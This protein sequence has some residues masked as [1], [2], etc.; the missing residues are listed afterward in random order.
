MVAD[1]MTVVGVNGIGHNWAIEEVAKIHGKLDS[2]C[3]SYMVL[4][5]K[6]L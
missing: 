6:T 5:T 4:S 2:V 3:H 1:R